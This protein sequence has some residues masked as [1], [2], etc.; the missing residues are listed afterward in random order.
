MLPNAFLSSCF[1]IVF[2]RTCKFFNFCIDKPLR[3]FGIPIDP[4]WPLLNCSS[5]S[6]KSWTWFKASSLCCFAS[7]ACNL[8]HICLSIILCLGNSADVSID[9]L[10][11][12]YIPFDCFHQLPISML[13]MLWLPAR[14]DPPM[15]MEGVLLFGLQNHRANVYH[16]SWN[17]SVMTVTSNIAYCVS[18]FRISYFLLNHLKA[19]HGLDWFPTI[20]WDSSKSR[21]EKNNMLMGVL[22][23]LHLRWIS[24]LNRGSLITYHPNSVILNVIGKTNYYHCERNYWF[25][26]MGHS[27][28]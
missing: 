11:N 1:G 12:L 19:H 3:S 22:F 24:T 9:F 14:F 6:V 7:V 16:L 15:Q 28:D 20:G 26:A 27:G 8:N 2:Q 4:F 10:S 21:E 17:Y 23:R 5:L 18:Y 13:H 25:L